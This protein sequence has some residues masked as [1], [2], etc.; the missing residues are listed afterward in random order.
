MT[1]LKSIAKQ[2]EDGKIKEQHL[3]AT[4]Y[5]EAFKSNPDNF[6]LACKEAANIRCATL[7]KKT[8]VKLDAIKENSIDNCTLLEG[9][10]LTGIEKK[11]GG[12]VI[13]MGFAGPVIVN[14]EF[15]KGEYYIPLATNEAALVAGVQR[16]MK[17]INMAGGINTAV[18][19]DGMARAPLLQA[20]DLY[21]ARSFCKRVVEDEELLSL[22][23]KEIK[24]PFV[25]LQYIEPTQMGTKVFL[26]LVCKTGDAMGM[27]GV[28]KAAADISRKLLQLL[29]DWKLLTIS[30]NM[31]SDKKSAHINILH[32]R[33]KSAN[34]EI[35]IPSEVLQKA[36]KPLVTPRKV[37][38]LIFNKCYLGSAI[39]GTLGGFNVNA[40]N[41]IAAF[42]A[43]CGQDL[44]H[45]VSSSTCFLQA[46]AVD[47]G[48]H[49][50]VSMPTLELATIGGGTN[51]GTAKE[52]LNLMGC[53]GYGT[54]FDDNSNVM[55][56]AEL[57]ITAVAALD[58]NTTCAQV[59]QFE[60]ADSHVKLARGE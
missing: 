7:E 39:S 18:T 21:S 1:N 36:F 3:E 56:L 52:A 25:K 5:A 11:I 42:F 23:E 24:D 4:I 14:G 16:G 49:Y 34:A 6:A 50:M 10:I 40:A 48:L 17:A 29:P 57:A 46:E 27:N 26:R 19:F 30:S 43:A 12:A 33:G 45:V 13:P 44:A 35:F 28:T 9:N 38:Q 32:G 8:N 54:S 53:G 41:V 60:M 15:A 31:C 51:F 55:R 59:D 58:L 47:G 22:L 20:P 2:Y 37:E